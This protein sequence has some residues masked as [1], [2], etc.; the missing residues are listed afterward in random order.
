MATTITS[1]QYTINWRDLLRGLLITVSGAVII[2][3]IQAF[4]QGGFRTINWDNVINTGISSG[5]AYLLKN[6]FTPGEIVVQNPAPAQIEAVK[7]GNAEVA[8]VPSTPPPDKE[9]IDI[10]KS[11]L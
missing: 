1:K 11:Q 7:T 2:T 9:L 8:L 6:F 3:L 10:N 5:L 4:N